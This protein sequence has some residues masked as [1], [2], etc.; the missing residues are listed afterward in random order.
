L[1]AAPA[2]TSEQTNGRSGDPSR[3]TQRRANQTRLIL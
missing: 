2:D 1:V 3:S